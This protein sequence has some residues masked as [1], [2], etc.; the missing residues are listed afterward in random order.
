MF[1]PVPCGSVN[2]SPKELQDKAQELTEDD[3]DGFLE[4][5]GCRVCYCNSL[6]YNL[7]KLRIEW[8]LLQEQNEL[9]SPNHNQVV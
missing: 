7:D 2:G 6:L 8:N 4:L 1:T 3:F 9:Q 5:C